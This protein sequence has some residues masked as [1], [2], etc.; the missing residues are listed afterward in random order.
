[1][2]ALGKTRAPAV[3]QEILAWLDGQP[4][5]AQAAAKPLFLYV[6]YLD[7]HEPYTAPRRSLEA[8]IAAKPGAEAKRAALEAAQWQWQRLSKSPESAWPTYIEDMYDAELLTFD[9][10]LQRFLTE[11]QTR[12]L[13]DNSVI[14]I[15]ADHGEAMREHGSGGHGHMLFEELLRVPLL[16]LQ[17]AGSGGRRIEAPV[18]L[19]DVAPTLLDA[20]GVAL[21]ETALGRSLQ[22][23]LRHGESWLRWREWFVPPRPVPHLPFGTV[24]AETAQD[25]EGFAARVQHRR[26]LVSEHYKVIEAVDGRHLVYDLRSDPGEQRPLPESDPLHAKLVQQLNAAAQLPASAAPPA[27]Q[28][29]LGNEVKEQMRALGYEER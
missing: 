10:D 25:T 2:E 8:V 27:Q 28:R 22:P 15:T 9:A 18:S 1:L 19:V 12:G 17:T 4:R 29:E 23:A 6:H 13:L 20:A 3:N 7:M 26:V 14:V 11:L 21:P 24:Y 5:S 16:V